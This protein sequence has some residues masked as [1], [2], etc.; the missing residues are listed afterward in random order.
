VCIIEFG[1]GKK[2]E[3]AKEWRK[4]KVPGWAVEVLAFLEA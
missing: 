1:C 2:G 4:V 3:I